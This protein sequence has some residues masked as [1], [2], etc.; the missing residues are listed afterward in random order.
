LP[1]C[2]IAKLPFWQDNETQI[3]CFFCFANKQSPS[4]RTALRCAYSAEPLS[5]ELCTQ[6]RQLF[7]N[8]GEREANYLLPMITQL[9]RT[10]IC[11]ELYPGAAKMK[12]QLSYADRN[13]IPFVVMVGENEMKEEKI[14]LKNMQSGDQKS[15]SQNEVRKKSIKRRLFAQLTIS[16]KEN[17]GNSG[18]FWFNYRMIFTSTAFIPFRP[19]S[20]RKV[21][22]WSS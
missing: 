18:V 19:R 1:N 3:Q 9:R 15:I 17:S 7:V 20:S 8:F 13:H 21:T 2:Q 6:H 14:T 16:Q 5:G 12:K 10:G 4:G 22:M 11:C